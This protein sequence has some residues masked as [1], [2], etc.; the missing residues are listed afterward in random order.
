MTSVLGPFFL[1]RLLAHSL[2]QLTWPQVW[3]RQRQSHTG[4]FDMIT[5]NLGR[6]SKAV[7]ISPFLLGPGNLQGCPFLALADVGAAS[8]GPCDFS[9]L[10]SLGALV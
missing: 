5:S 9:V 8:G 4:C 10:V 3:T 6:L 2:G 1:Q 7:T